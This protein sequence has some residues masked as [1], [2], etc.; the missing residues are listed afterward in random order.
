MDF[1]GGMLWVAPKLFYRSAVFCWRVK[2][3]LLKKGAV[4]ILNER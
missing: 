3:I 2:L 1:Y 4:R